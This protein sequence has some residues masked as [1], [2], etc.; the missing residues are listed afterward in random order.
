MRAAENRCKTVGSNQK[1]K[2]RIS[3]FMKIKR[4]NTNGN[5]IYW[6]LLVIYVGTIIILSWNWVYGIIAFIS[7]YLLSKLWFTTKKLESDEIKQLE[8]AS[9]I[10]IKYLERRNPLFWGTYIPLLLMTI[11]PNEENPNLIWHLA[12]F[13]IIGLI[14]IILVIRGKDKIE[15][16]IFITNSQLVK[17]NSISYPIVI[18]VEDVKSFSAKKKYLRIYEKYG[19][20]EIKINTQNQSKIQCLIKKMEKN[21]EKRKAAANNA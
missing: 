18:N 4:R 13:A 10:K 19:E 3:D 6:I 15:T 17:N 12:V 11:F 8:E 16:V 2:K 14:K 20:C 1:K 21:I 5:L 7:V 9:E